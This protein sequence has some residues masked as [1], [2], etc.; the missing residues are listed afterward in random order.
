MHKEGNEQ[1]IIYTLI[2]WSVLFTFT[3][4]VI[5][6]PV[7]ISFL[8]KNIV[9][10]IIEAQSVL[11][12]KYNIGTRVLSQNKIFAL[13]RVRVIKELVPIFYSAIKHRYPCFIS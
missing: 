13:V 4:R 2:Y 10:R 5:K 1:G 7:N 6:H 11:E 3:V 8:N 12:S 9:Q